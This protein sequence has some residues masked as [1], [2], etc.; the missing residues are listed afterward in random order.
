MTESVRHNGGGED[1]GPD[2]S[3]GHSER[4]RWR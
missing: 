1:G 2:A 4:R 3:L